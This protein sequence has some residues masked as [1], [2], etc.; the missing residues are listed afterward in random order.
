[1][2][3][4]LSSAL[5]GPAQRLGAVAAPAAA[6]TPMA[7]SGL[8]S[9]F[10]PQAAQSPLYQ[11]FDQRRNV[12]M[13]A[14]LGGVGAESPLERLRGI[15]Q[16]ALKGREADT[17]YGLEI[18]K[19]AQQKQAINKT[20]ELL[21]QKRPDLVP[22]VE[23][24]AITPVD[25]FKMLY[26]GSDASVYGTPIYGTDAQGKQVLGVIGKDGTFKKLD[27]GGVTP[28]PGVQWQD[29]GTYRQGFGKGGQ[30]VTPQIGIDN[31]GKG[32]DSS[33]GDVA[34][35]RAGEL[36]VM[37]NK[38]LSSMDALDN[39][40]MVVEDNIG[41]AIS[42]IQAN[43]GITTGLVGGIA[44]A[45]P[46]SPAY[47]L[48]SKLDTIKANVGFDKLQSMRENS[49]TGGALGQVSDFENRQLQAIFGNL[50]QAQTAEDLLYNLQM[51]RQV[52]AN[53]RDARR[54]A[55]ARD[56]G[57]EVGVPAPSPAQA[58]QQPDAGG[59]RFKYNP[60]TGELE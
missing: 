13:G 14:L 46:G 25:A 22:W 29:F 1:M 27:T 40:R 55:F 45:V 50:D 3:G 43:P 47:A 18:K 37:K 24:G 9:M 23:S 16:G 30:P 17:A 8:L 34:G 35:K 44:S 2:A 26:G 12:L 32:Y 54:R 10:A 33:A 59:Q 39:Q 52:L 5:M 58:P 15:A 48:K 57:E 51:L 60:A 21:T 28:T 20:L 42:D 7:S 11:A 49:P 38:A 41:R 31:Y 36:P 6:A 4:L 56:F 53:S 19:E